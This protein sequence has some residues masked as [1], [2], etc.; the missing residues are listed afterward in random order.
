MTFANAPNPLAS[1]VILP[2]PTTFSGLSCETFNATVRS[3]AV[4]SSYAP[5]NTNSYGSEYVHN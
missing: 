4:P 1:T 5:G 3:G 2:A